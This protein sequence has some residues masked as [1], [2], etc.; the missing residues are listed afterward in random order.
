MHKTRLY[1]VGGLS[2]PLPTRGP[3]SVLFS[4]KRSNA[5][6]QLLYHSLSE[7]AEFDAT[8]FLVRIVNMFHQL[9]D[10]FCVSFGFKLE[11]VLYLHTGQHAN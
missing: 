8:P 4:L 1:A 9:R 2:S 3:H 6:Y 7:R 5:T 10:R 11:T